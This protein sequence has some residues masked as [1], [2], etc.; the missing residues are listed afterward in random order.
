MRKVIVPL[1]T[2][3]EGFCKTIKAQYFK[4][5][6][7]NFTFFEPGGFGATGVLEYV[8]AGDCEDDTD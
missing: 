4:N 5:G 1:N 7:R 8:W 3:P 2:T 6:F